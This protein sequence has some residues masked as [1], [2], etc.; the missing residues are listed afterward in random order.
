MGPDTALAVEVGDLTKRFDGLTA[1]DGISFSI[2]QGEVFG[3][4]GPNGAGKTTT[5]NMLTGLARPDS[6]TIHIGGRIRSRF[7]KG[8]RSD[9][10]LALCTGQARS[11]G[12]AAAWGG[13][14]TDLPAEGSGNTVTAVTSGKA[15]RAWVGMA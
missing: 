9:G 11:Q 5:I 6:G 13:D 7:G 1:V 8:S 12:N 15:A 3:L 2:M 10:A 4:L 14:V